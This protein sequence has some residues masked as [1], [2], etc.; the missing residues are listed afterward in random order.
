MKKSSSLF[1]AGQIAAGLA[2]AAIGYALLP[3]PKRATRVVVIT[4]GSRGLGF[5]LAERFGRA[6]D[7][8]VLAARN[9]HELHQARLSLLERGMVANEDDI[10]LVGADITD[11]R[12]ASGLIAETIDAFGRIDVLINN[13]AIIEVGPYLDQPLEAYRRAMDTNFF[14]ALHTISAAMPHLLQSKAS[15]GRDASIVNISSIGGKIAVPHLLPY[16]ASKFALT[17]FS[18]GLHAELRHKGVRVTTVCPGLMRSG[19]EAHAKFA[20]QVEKEKQW[21]QLAATTPLVASDVQHAANRIFNAVEAGRAEITISPQ[22]WLAARFAG[23]CPESY[24]AIAGLVN[25]WV[26][27]APSDAK[28]ASEGTPEQ[29]PVAIAAPS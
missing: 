6:G 1:Y 28:L 29:A 8:L 13:A 14:A 2:A 12:Q 21:F 20:G 3:K 9:E 10:H 17:G 22:A 16:V 11:A 15:A 24:Q 23:L 27:P 4:G 25:E 26:L 7:R 18:E 5:A 19:G